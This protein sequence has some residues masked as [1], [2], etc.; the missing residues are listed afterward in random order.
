MPI[1]TVAV[2]S[3]VNRAFHDLTPCSCAM[4]VHTAAD[5]GSQL[6]SRPMSSSALL[7]GRL[8]WLMTMGDRAF[9]VAGSRL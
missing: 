2:C 6:F 4:Y 1:D 7:T 3:F 5:R 9:L 8:T